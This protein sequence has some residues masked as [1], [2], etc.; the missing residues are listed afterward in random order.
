M[1][2]IGVGVFSGQCRALMYG[3]NVTR[4]VSADAGEELHDAVHG[5][6]YLEHMAQNDGPLN[7]TL[8]LAVGVDGFSPFTSKWTQN[9]YLMPCKVSCFNLDPLVRHTKEVEW[10]PFILQGKAEPDPG[11]ALEVMADELMFGHH[12]GFHVTN[13][14]ANPEVGQFKCRVKLILLRADYRGLHKLCRRAGAPS[15]VGACYKCNVIGLTRGVTNLKKTMYGGI[16]SRFCLAIPMWHA[17]YNIPMYG[18]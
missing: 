18:I 11:F 8:A 7:R 15:K 12:V 13:D 16:V 6:I 17:C 9:T 4:P 10:I 5:S 3:D 2:F 14:M 1:S